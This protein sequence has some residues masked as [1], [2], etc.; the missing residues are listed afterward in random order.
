MST[1]LPNEVLALLPTAEEAPRCAVHSR[2]IGVRPAGTAITADAVVVV[3]LPRPWPKP[4]FDHPLLGAL[5]GTMELHV[6]TARILAAEP[7][8]G[9]GEG[10]LRVTVFER[11]P[12]DMTARVFEP[13]GAEGL[14]DLFGQLAT[15]LPDSIADHRSDAA[16][17]DLAVLICTQGSHDVCCGSE[18]TR[19]ADELSIA[20]PG[21]AVYRVS[22]TGGHR[23][24]P[25]AMTLPDGRMWA[26]LTVDD[27][28]SILDRTGDPGTLAAKCR[29]WL[30]A[31]QGAGQ[32]AEIAVL[33]ELGWTLDQMP[34][35]V[36]VTETG[37]GWTVTVVVGTDPWT[38][39]VSPGR[40][41]P[42]IAC[43]AAGGLP[44]KTALEYRVE[45]L[46]QT[47][48]KPMPPSAP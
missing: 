3:E 15:R 32:A 30:G 6:G 34:R 26:G 43:R 27:L 4:V 42:T 9:L 45:R 19:L 36:E 5:S 46:A 35:A 39:D 23:F 18:G 22:H 48:R 12:V 37:E 44:A 33:E 11:L 8:P 41:V 40:T 20:A 14:S 2:S 1:A 7:R 28:M 47:N 21:L 29:G 13:T 25:T 10:R 38:V 17:P 31:P 16:G 24:A